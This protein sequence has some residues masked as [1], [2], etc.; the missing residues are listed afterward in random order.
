MDDVEKNE[1]CKKTEVKSNLKF[2]WVVDTNGKSG[3][4]TNTGD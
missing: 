4:R 1:L 2:D 3:G